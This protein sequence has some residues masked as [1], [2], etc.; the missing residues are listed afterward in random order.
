MQIT[1]SQHYV[2]RNYLRS[3]ARD[4]YIAMNH[5]GKIINRIAVKNVAQENYFYRHELLTFDEFS[6][7]ISYIQHNKYLSPEYLSMYIEANFLPVLLKKITTGDCPEAKLFIDKFEKEHLLPVP[8]IAILKMMSENSAFLK[9]LSPPKEIKEQ[10]EG[11]IAEGDEPFNC[12]VEELAWKY[13]SALLQNDISGIISD[14]GF[15]EFSLFIIHQFFRTNKFLTSIP[16]FIEKFGEDGMRRICSFLRFP[17]VNQVHSYLCAKK[18]E[19]SFY[20][21]INNTDLPFITGDQPLTNLDTNNPSDFFDLFYPISPTRALLLCKKERWDKRYSS[22][23]NIDK[24]QVNKLNL[25]ICSRCL[26]QI[27][28]TSSEVLEKNSYVAACDYE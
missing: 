27:Y 3:W 20:L 5:N 12:D 28:A 10:F 9:S 1:K 17:L 4:G 24:E 25:M 8:L 22:F 7:A 21:I 11:M 15:E 6:F 16:L 26:K 14:N 2:P 13:F 23:K 18:D 19:Y